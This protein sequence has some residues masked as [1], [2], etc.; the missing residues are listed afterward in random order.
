MVEGGVK[1]LHKFYL[2]ESGS[3]NRKLVE[4]IDLEKTPLTGMFIEVDGSPFQITR[5]TTVRNFT[6]EPLY[7]RVDLNNHAGFTIK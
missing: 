4:N 6:G 2:W 3:A 1:M 7:T 5:V